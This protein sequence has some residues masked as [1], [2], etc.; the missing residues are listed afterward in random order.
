MSQQRGR[1]S[2]IV[3]DVERARAETAPR[4]RR[5]RRPL[6]IALLVV[7]GLVVVAL[8]GGYAWWQSYRKGPAY[9]LALLVDAARRDDLAAVE[10]LIDGDRVAQGFI[11]QVIEKLTGAGA[12][13]PPDARQRVTAAMPALLPRVRETVR[14]EIARG[15]KAAASQ[16]GDTSFTLLALGIPRAAEI[17]EDGDAATA[18]FA[19]EGRQTEVAMQRSGERWK[20]VSVKDDELASGIAQRLAASIPPGQPPPQQNQPRR[21]QGR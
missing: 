1:K 20:V 19:R 11:P 9:S 4:G 12:A 6:S 13:L 18:T 8:V 14:E 10:S 17:K 15:M 21:R 7:V 16:L 2:R 5:A 3:I